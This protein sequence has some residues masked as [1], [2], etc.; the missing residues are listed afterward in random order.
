MKAAIL[1]VSSH[2]TIVLLGTDRHE[3]KYWRFYL[4]GIVIRVF[5]AIVPCVIFQQQIMKG[6][7]VLSIICN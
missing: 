1:L 5:V 7:S 2:S 6:T 4:Q 3:G